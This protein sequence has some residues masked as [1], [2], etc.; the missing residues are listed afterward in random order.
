MTLKA[1]TTFQHE[2]RRKT[3]EISVVV[4]DILRGPVMATT[5]GN[6]GMFLGGNKSFSNFKFV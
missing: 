6:D 1:P 3:N 4:N 5:K 2:S